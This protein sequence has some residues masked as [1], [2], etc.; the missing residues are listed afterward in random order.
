MTG[1]PAN[2]GAAGA[3]R[4][5]AAAR[6]GRQR[7]AWAG[8]AARDAGAGPIVVVDNPRRRLEAHLRAGTLIAIQPEPKG[9]GDAVAA[10]RQHLTGTVVVINGDVPLLTA[11]A[12][13]KLVEAHEQAGAAATMAT[14]EPPDPGSYGRVVR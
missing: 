3:T 12:I 11:E 2:A 4:A 14:M 5:A 1:T 6:G 10:A 13:A 9:T 8:A 7:S